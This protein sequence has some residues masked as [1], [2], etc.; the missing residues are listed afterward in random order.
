MST[1]GLAKIR[2]GTFDARDLDS[3]ELL[4]ISVFFPDKFAPS[5]LIRL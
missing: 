4:G 2:P 1:V 5:F 3:S